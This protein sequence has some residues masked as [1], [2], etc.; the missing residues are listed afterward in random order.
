[1]MST[2]VKYLLFQAPEWTLLGLILLGLW[3]WLGLPL[4]IG[5]GILSL[6]VVKDL[7][8]YPYV[9]AAFEGEPKTGPEKLVGARG[10]AQE[11]L[12]PKGYVKIHGELWRAEADCGDQPVSPGNPVRVRKAKGLTLL[13]TPEKEQSQAGPFSTGNRPS[14]G[15]P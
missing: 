12:S 13:V 2:R 8:L 10:I 3:K 15:E 9:R 7:L 14:T 1:M 4:W 11:E 5:L 6:W